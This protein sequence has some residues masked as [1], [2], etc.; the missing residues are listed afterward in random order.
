MN[1]KRGTQR[2]ACWVLKVVYRCN[3]CQRRRHC[4]SHIFCPWGV[5]LLVRLSQER[6][7]PQSVRTNPHEL[8]RT[9]G[10]CVVR[11]I[12][13]PDNGPHTF[14]WHYQVGTL[15]WINFYPS[16]GHL[17]EDE[18]ARGHFQRVG[19]PAHTQLVFPWRVC[20]MC[21]GTEKF[22]KTFAHEGRQIVQSHIITCGNLWKVQVENGGV[23]PPPSHI[24]HG[25]VHNGTSRYRNDYICL[26]S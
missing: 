24:P 15:L 3:C 14:R 13:K 25:I 26:T 5:V 10:W 1:W 23:I 21:A 4:G 8:T 22:Q 16:T 19:V 20:A 6:A 12:T 7:Q 17:N 11:R 18:I 2:Q 9:E